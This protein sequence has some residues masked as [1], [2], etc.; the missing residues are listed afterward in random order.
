MHV[1]MLAF[2]TYTRYRHQNHCQIQQYYN[3]QSGLISQVLILSLSLSQP[4]NIWVQTERLNQSSTLFIVN[5][6]VITI[7]VGILRLV[8][9]TNRYNNTMDTASYHQI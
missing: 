8:T 1:C 3:V 9:Y 4:L 7:R 2:M 5:N 6:K